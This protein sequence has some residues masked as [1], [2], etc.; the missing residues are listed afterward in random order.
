MLTGVRA[1][2]S[3]DMRVRSLAAWILV[4]AIVTTGAAAN[5]Q[6]KE[7]QVW[8]DLAA[9]ESMGGHTLAR[10]VGK[11]DSQLSDRLRRE[12]QI[13]AASTYTDREMAERTV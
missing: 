5:Q 4:C 9:D 6:D 3:M 11:T 8:R 12:P 13:S 7:R 1:S 2:Y 10:H